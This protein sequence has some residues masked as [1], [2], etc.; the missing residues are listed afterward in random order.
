MTKKQASQLPELLQNFIMSSEMEG[1]SVSET[2]QE[3]CMNVLSGKATLE[4]CLT[5]INR[6]YAGM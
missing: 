5:Q 3:M 1:L 6:K 2:M 4:E